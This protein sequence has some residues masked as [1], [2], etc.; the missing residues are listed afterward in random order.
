MADFRPHMI[1]GLRA[2]YLYIR[3]R[4]GAT[5][6]RRPRWCPRASSRVA[7]GR[8]RA[9]AV[10]GWGRD[11]GAR[12]RSEGGRAGG[13]SSPMLAPDRVEPGSCASAAHAGVV[14][15]VFRTAVGPI[16]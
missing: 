1:H 11:E 9:Y 7:L 15:S 8:A 5:P 12:P 4:A 13:W 3:L 16:C 10:S 2:V 14:S 6:G